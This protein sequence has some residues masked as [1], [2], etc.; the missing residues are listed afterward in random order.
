MSAFMACP[1]NSKEKV[2]HPLCSEEVIM[3]Q[4]PIVLL[5]RTF[6]LLLSGRIRRPKIIEV[7]SL[8]VEDETFVPFR[9]ICVNPPKKQK[10]PRRGI[11]Q[12]RFRF[13]N[14]SPAANRRLSLI[15]IPLILAQSGFHSKTWLLGQDSGDFIGYYEFESIK[16]AEAYWHS[17]PLKMMR[18]RAA[19]ESLT[20]VIKE[21]PCKEYKN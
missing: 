10:S 8:M 7:G 15:P 21:A 2:E 1:A 6:W 5:G 14:L 9:K 4:N 17:L 16:A 3:S 13:K 19:P 18:R 11:F 20:H 12:V